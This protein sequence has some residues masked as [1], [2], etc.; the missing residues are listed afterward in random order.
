MSQQTID[1]LNVKDFK[2]VYY[3]PWDAQFLGY[4]VVDYDADAYEK[5]VQRLKAYDSTDYVGYYSVTEEKTYDLLAVN[6]DSYHGFVY[7]LTDGNGRIPGAKQVVPRHG[8]DQ[9]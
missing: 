8:R 5:E 9:F 4:M 7:A 2:M 3:N 1:K 6:S